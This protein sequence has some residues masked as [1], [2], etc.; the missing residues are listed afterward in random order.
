MNSDRKAD[1]YVGLDMGTGSLGVAVTDP[2]YHL[3]K[4]TG[5]DFWF[6][7]EYE[8]AHPQ[9]ERRTHRISKRRLQRHQVR[10]GLI[11]SIL[12]MMCWNMILFFILDRITA[13]IIEKIKIPDC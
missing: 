4:V 13:N 5:K 10:I 11:R 3:L 6:V 9:L 2:Q 7:R 8:T 1:Y 12:Q